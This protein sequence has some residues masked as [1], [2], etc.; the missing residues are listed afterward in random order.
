MTARI[1]IPADVDRADRVLAG[2]TA[3]QLTIAATAGLAAWAVWTAASQQLPAALAA[4]LATPPLLAG[5]V[6]VVGRRDGL[7]LDRLLV[8]GLGWWRRPRRVVPAP[9]GVTAPPRWAAPADRARPPA[10]MGGLLRRLD[11]GGLVDLGGDGQALLCRASPVNFRLRTPAEQQQ[12]VAAFARLLQALDAPMQLLV[13]A[14]PVDLHELVAALEGGAASLPHPALEATTRQHA[15]F[16]RELAGRRDLLRRELLLVFR[17]PTPGSDAHGRL[18]RRAEQAAD[19]LAAA[20]VAV[21][22]LDG[23][24]VAAAVLAR[25]ADPYRPP[26][27]AGLAAPG[28]VITGR[29]R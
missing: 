20:G 7:P 3:R 17:D 23:A 8:A 11:P 14:D 5:L 4:A 28:E 12:L 2:L 15:R 21:S 26:R 9:D 22:P 13:R 19:L 1:R 18:A 10:P 16:L 27:P 24:N 29:P 25:A 6:L